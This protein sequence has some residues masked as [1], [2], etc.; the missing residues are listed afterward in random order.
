[1][2]IFKNLLITSTTTI[3]GWENSLTE[4][5]IADDSSA[6][7]EAFELTFNCSFMIPKQAIYSG[8]DLL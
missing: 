2:G 6:G 5:L 7:K 3:P 1:M 4:I 8:G